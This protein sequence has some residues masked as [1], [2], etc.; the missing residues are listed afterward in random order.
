MKES[1]RLENLHAHP[2][3][4]SLSIGV[5]HGYGTFYMPFPNTLQLRY[6]PYFMIRI[7]MD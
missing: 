7:F 4:I 1:V 5:T 6:T 2:T 3:N